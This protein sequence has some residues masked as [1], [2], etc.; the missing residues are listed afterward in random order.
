M[1]V[2]P[3]RSIN[4]PGPTLVV[5][6]LFRYNLALISLRVLSRCQAPSDKRPEPRVWDPVVGKSEIKSDGRGSE[7]PGRCVCA[8]GVEASEQTCCGAKMS[9]GECEVDWICNGASA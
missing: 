6:V 7:K 9:S 8:A 1:T 2:T 4:L 3:M 5:G